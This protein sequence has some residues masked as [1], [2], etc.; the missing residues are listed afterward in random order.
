MY[1]HE[2]HRMR[3]IRFQLHPEP[4]YV[5][6]DS[7]S[8]RW[9]VLVN[10]HMAKQLFARNGTSGIMLQKQ[11]YTAL[12]KA[13]WNDS[14]G[15]NQSQL[16]RVEPNILAKM[17]LL[18]MELI[19]HPAYHRV[20]ACQQLLGTK[21]FG[22]VIVSAKFQQDNLVHRIGMRAED[23][24]GS[25]AINP[26]YFAEDL[27]ATKFR[28]VKV[29]QRDARRPVAKLLQAHRSCGRDA[30]LATVKFE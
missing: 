8:R 21:G 25:F 3:W 27:L 17:D 23:H 4:P 16:R 18:S 15:A 19:L 1:R 7:Q 5:G 22:D 6:L 13:E 2:V 9:A 26:L 12:S 29:Q 10:P 28:E 20:N 24:D 11:K 14:V 30:H